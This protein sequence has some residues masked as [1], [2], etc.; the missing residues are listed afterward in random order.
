MAYISRLLKDG[1]TR[2]L[3][4]LL[5]FKVLRVSG[6]ILYAIVLTSNKFNLN[7]RRLPHYLSI[8]ANE[9]KGRLY[10]DALHGA[11]GPVVVVGGHQCGGSR[12]RGAHRRNSIFVDLVEKETEVVAQRCARAAVW[13]GG[14]ER[15]VFSYADAGANVV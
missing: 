13:E 7:A 4:T 15:G 3:L 6:P 9:R 2:W 10:P 11:T 8:F 1:N 5:R 12:G 14:G